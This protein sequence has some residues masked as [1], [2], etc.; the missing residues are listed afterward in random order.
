MAAGSR[1]PAERGVRLA[2]EM[3][4]A[5]QELSA[6]WKKRG[7]DLGLGI[8]VAQGF[9]GPQ[10]SRNDRSNSTRGDSPCKCCSASASSR[11]STALLK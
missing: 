8:G 1:L 6:K 3:R 7:V 9:A 5:A 10:W 4:D 11:G 2:V